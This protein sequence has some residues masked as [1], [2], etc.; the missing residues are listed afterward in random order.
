METEMILA[1]TIGAVMFLLGAFIG[2]GLYEAGAR[3]LRAQ[4]E[5]AIKEL[6]LSR[7]EIDGL[8]EATGQLATLNYHILEAQAHEKEQQQQLAIFASQFKGKPS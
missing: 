5:Q 1:I 6:A 3:P 4:N 2:A 8:I 7:M